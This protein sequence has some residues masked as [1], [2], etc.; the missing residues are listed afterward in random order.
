MKAP[1]L[2]SF[3]K[4]LNNKQFEMPTRYYNERKERIEKAINK[5]EGKK[6]EE[7]KKGHFS[8]SWKNKTTMGSASSSL[9]IVFIIVI[10][11]LIAYWILKL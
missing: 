5:A 7:L 3:F 1:K 10:L 2:P 9:R 6:D 8:R 4:T 11:C